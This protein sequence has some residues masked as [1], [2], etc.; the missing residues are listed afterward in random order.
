MKNKR[1]YGTTALLIGLIL[2]FTVLSMTL[3][4]EVDSDMPRAIEAQ[5]IEKGGK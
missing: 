5:Q 1:R 3:F 2:L 4:A